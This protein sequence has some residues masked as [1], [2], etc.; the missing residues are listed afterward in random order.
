MKFL[1]N[2]LLVL[3]SVFAF[4]QKKEGKMLID[5]LEQVI[6]TIKNEKTKVDLYNNIAKEYRK[7]DINF[8]ES[9]ANKALELAKKIKYNNGIA[10]SY[11]NL[12][13]VSASKSNFSEAL[14]NYEFGLKNATS[15]SIKGE[16]LG[17]IGKVYSLKS[18]YPTALKYFFESLQLFEEVNNKE[19]QSITLQNISTIYIYLGDAEKAKLYRKKSDSTKNI[20]IA[21]NTIPLKKELNNSKINCLVAEKDTLIKNNYYLD[22]LKNAEKKGLNLEKTKYLI[23]E[24][25]LLIDNQKYDNALQILIPLL[26][27]EELKPKNEAQ[28]AAIYYQFGDIYYFKAQQEKSNSLKKE[29]NKKS[30][31]SYEK[32]IQLISK[33]H[34]LDEKQKRYFKLHLAYKQNNDF[35]NSLLAYEKATLY[36]DSIFNFS[37]KETIKNLEDKREIDLKNNQIKIKNLTL[38]SNKKQKYYF[39]GGIF[40]LAIIGSLLFYQSRNRKKTNEKLQVL[41]TELDE[42]NKAKTRFFSILNHD[43]RGPVANLVFFLQLQKES[44]EMLDEESTKRMQDKT[45]VGAEN[46]LNS[47]EDILQWSKSQMENFKPQPKKIAISSLFEDTKSHFSSEEKV[48]IT[49]ENPQ[50]IQINTDENYLKTIIR[51]LT[52][53]AIKALDGI[54]NPSI[55]WKT[56]QE[57]NFTYLS[58]S[59]NGK[60][61][62]NEQFKALYD[63]KE[64]TGIKTGLGLHLIRDLAKAIDC[65]ILV[66]SKIDNGT[67][68]TLKLK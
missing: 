49:F 2:L 17:G 44:P 28:I 5:S 47:M 67:T 66:D 65:E 46:L 45:M 36:K 24:C 12:G 39:I 54:D 60:G 20:R 6:P 15:K 30:I 35:Q 29:L 52:G 57:N 42:A 34:L 63:E 4:C 9:Y 16:I 53:N 31:A 13:I 64:V 32:S 38:E 50:N 8:C 3:L 21:I 56:W 7:I 23:N 18:D 25:R 11:R 37:K 58:I 22:V 43:L 48:Q 62:S 19:L 1:L 61:A 40:L 10:Y 51:N 59:D 68:F 33:L 26:K 41:N 27:T 14:S 55:I